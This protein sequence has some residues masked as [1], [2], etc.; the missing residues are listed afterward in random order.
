MISPRTV[1]VPQPWPVSSRIVSS[2]LQALPRGEL[3]GETD[4]I[5]LREE[6]Q[7]IVEHVLAVEVPVADRAVA[8][9]IDAEN[10][11]RLL[12]HALRA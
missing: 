7:R 2:R 5:R 1:N 6:D 8:Q 12:G 9:E 10:H 11:Q 4:R 3:L